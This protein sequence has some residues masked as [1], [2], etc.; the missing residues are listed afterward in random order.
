MLHLFSYESKIWMIK[1]IRL[2]QNRIKRFPHSTE[3]TLVMSN[4]K[5]SQQHQPH[6]RI[7]SLVCFHDQLLILHHFSKFLKHR[8]WLIKIYRH[9]NSGK[10]FANRFSHYF[11]NCHFFIRVFQNVKFRSLH[12]FIRH[13]FLGGASINIFQTFFFNFL[14]NNIKFLKIVLNTLILLF[15]GN[16][17]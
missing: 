7:F 3:S 4:L 1:F 6:Y 11:P 12:I 10:V 15:F 9:W 16:F 8:K 13:N 17:F 2:T 5:R 14:L